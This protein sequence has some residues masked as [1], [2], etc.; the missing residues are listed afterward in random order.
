MIGLLTRPYAGA[1]AQILIERYFLFHELCGGVALAHLVAE[2]LYMGKPLQRLTLWLLLGIFALGLVGGHS[3]QPK[4]RAPNDLRP[5]FDSSTNRCGQTVLQ[6]LARCIAGPQPGR[7]RRRGRVSLARHN[8]G[9]RLPV[10]GLIPGGMH[11]VRRR[12]DNQ[13]NPRVCEPAKP[14]RRR[15]EIGAPHAASLS[16]KFVLQKNERLTIFVTCQQKWV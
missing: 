11:P 1:A 14:W 10:S 2:W 13:A 3:L 15:W 6:T 9:Q 4:L 7:S 8:P 16:Y 12:R 5:R